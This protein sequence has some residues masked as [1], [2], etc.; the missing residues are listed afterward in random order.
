MNENWKQI[1][2][3]PIGYEISNFGRSRK[4]GHYFTSTANADGYHKFDYGDGQTRLVHKLVMSCFGPRNPFNAMI[5]HSDDDLSN[6]RIDN[7]RWMPIKEWA[8]MWA[9]R[10]ADQRKYGSNPSLFGAST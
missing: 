1:Y 9:V 3:L 7:L 4:D 2:G 5:R 8:S 6:N 10:A